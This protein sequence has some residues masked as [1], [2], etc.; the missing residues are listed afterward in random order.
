MRDASEVIALLD[1]I[2]NAWETEARTRKNGPGTLSLK[3]CAETLRE[4]AKV[5][6]TRPAST[7]PGDD[8]VRHACRRVRLE[9]QARIDALSASGDAVA[10]RD[11]YIGVQARALGA[12][13]AKLARVDKVL[14]EFE[15]MTG[16]G[17]RYMAEHV[18]AAMNTKESSH[19]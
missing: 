11:A 19:A 15:G 2:A 5:I 16:A 3:R 7:P 14:R 10:Q 13:E 1:S 12:A 17:Y 18:R 8:C 9:M 4:H 6:A